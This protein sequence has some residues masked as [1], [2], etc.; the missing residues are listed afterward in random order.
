MRILKVHFKNLNSL[1]G[2]FTVDFNDAAYRSTGIF[3]ITGPTGAGKTTVLD[4]VCLALYGQTPRL[5]KVTQGENEIMSRRRGECFAEVTFETVKGTFRCHWQ[6]RRA[7][8]IPGARLQAPRHEIAAVDP[9]TDTGRVIASKLKEVAA[10]VEEVSGL[11]FQRFTK[12]VLLAQNGF[13]AFLE[14]APDK[15]SPLLEQITGTEIYSEISRKTHELRAEKKTALDIAAAEVEG[16]AL[17]SDEEIAALEEEREALSA[18][19]TA[20]AA[21][22]R[23]VE[24]AAAWL[25]RLAALEEK[26]RDI[27]AR[28]AALAKDKAAAAA[29]LAALEPAERAHRLRDAYGRVASIR[30]Q[31]REAEAALAESYARLPD[32]GE[33]KE[34]CDRAYRESSADLAG[35]REREPEAL[36]RIKAARKLEVQIGELGKQLDQWHR[37]VRRD[38][39]DRRVQQQALDTL[40][41]RFELGREQLDTCASY[42]ADHAADGALAATYAGIEAE[43]N[44][45]KGLHAKHGRDRDTLSHRGAAVAKL[46]GALAS[47]ARERAEAEAIHRARFLE[48][49]RAHLVDGEPC[50]LCGARGHPLGGETAGT[51]DSPGAFG[52][53]ERVLLEKARQAD[54]I[55]RDL[56]KASWEK[57]TLAAQVGVQAEELEA[58]LATG[59][60]ALAPYGVRA[61]EVSGIDG[62]L[63]DLRRR[64]DRFDSQRGRA[65]A[66]RREVEGLRSDIETRRARI[67]DLDERLQATRRRVAALDADR[68]VF[69]EQRT[70]LLAGEG[71]DEAEARLRAELERAKARQ[72]ADRETLSDIQQELASRKASVAERLERVAS[73]RTERTQFEAA[74]QGALRE[75]G[76]TDEASFLAAR[77]EPARLRELTAL[78]E[79]L[80]E[81]TATLETLAGDTAASLRKERE[82][83][84][85]EDSL[86]AVTG[87]IAALSDRMAGHQER[88]GAIREALKKDASLAAVRASKLEEIT[89]K[90]RELQRFGRLHEL[91]GSAD[92]K[93][94]RNFAQGLTFEHM[95]VLAN[96]ELRKMSDRYLLRRNDDI[97]LELEVMDNYQAGHTRSTKNLSGG[98]SF[99]VSLALALGLS[100]MASRNIRVDSLFLDE[101]FG[102]LDEEALEVALQTLSELHRGDKLIGVI[103]HVPALRER[104]PN[105]IRVTPIAGGRSTL[106]GPG[107]SAAPKR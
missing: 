73:L 30:D 94:F 25:R 6:Q 12:S 1:L 17:L 16:I 96:E 84:L 19:M 49:E 86:E 67:A 55:R 78:R 107:C 58:A 21:E 41:G 54:G 83:K 10:M 72:E 3:A 28:A 102:T 5:G 44:R 50:P 81:E 105:Q 26:Q 87:R 39:G 68:T 48:E 71:P 40:L 38:E 88:I 60:A 82:A 11:D 61:L 89:G 51:D 47:A 59:R 24:A 76:F 45:M 37:E 92:G 43:L 79:R 52:T 90:R 93:K 104:I 20:V 34:S 29:H 22:R 7:K 9:A 13:A 63:A 2:T 27:Q 31:E 18:A 46:E 32:L 75:S 91:I 53:A 98:E 106:S 33:E 80:R 70:A 100:G 103:S 65:E 99:I 74:F 36:E 62:V 64:R 66:L 77:L 8:R 95:I 15:R 42:E 97:P 56:E 23:G 85:T 35:L 69:L 101:G 14:A 4:A 57:E